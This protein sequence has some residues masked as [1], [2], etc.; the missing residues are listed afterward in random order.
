MS[1]TTSARRRVQP[2]DRRSAAATRTVRKT[3]LDSAVTIGP[4]A[5]AMN[6]TNEFAAAYDGH[7]GPPLVIALA[8]RAA[9]A[10]TPIATPSRSPARGS[11]RLVASHSG[12][13]P[14]MSAI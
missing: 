10:T 11:S 13:A 6:G 14:A 1:K 5:D 4:I 12:A 3:I 8:A 2:A 7:A 9:A